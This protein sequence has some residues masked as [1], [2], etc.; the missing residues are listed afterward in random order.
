MARRRGQVETIMAVGNLACSRVAPFE[1]AE[2]RQRLLAAR[3]ALSEGERAA[4]DAA[5]IERLNP[6]IIQAQAQR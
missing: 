4:A 1:R 5:L 2:V 3:N 6:I